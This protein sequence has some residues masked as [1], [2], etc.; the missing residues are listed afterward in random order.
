MAAYCE[1]VGVLVDIYRATKELL[2]AYESAKIVASKKGGEL[3]EIRGEF[4]RVMGVGSGLINFRG[5]LNMIEPHRKIAGTMV[6]VFFFFTLTIPFLLMS[7]GRDA[8]AALGL[9]S[10]VI[11]AAGIWGFILLLCFLDANDKIK[12]CI[13][14][15]GESMFKSKTKKEK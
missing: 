9:A 12:E 3:A 4:R 6:Y 14:S 13:L 8:M 15:D 7:T 11:G 2:D 5:I 10:M 1:I